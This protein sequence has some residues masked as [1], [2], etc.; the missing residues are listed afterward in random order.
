MNMKA[1]GSKTLS[2]MAVTLAL[3]VTATPVLAKDAKAKQSSASA[4]AA[5]KALGGVPDTSSWSAKA[6]HERKP[7][8]AWRTIGGTVKQIKG[9]TYMVEDYEGNQVQVYVGNETKHLKQKKVGDTVRAEI[10]RGGF[11]NSIQ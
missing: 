2:I 3:A 4:E 5:A 9:D 7:G 6:Q 8:V 11:A 1:I 10:T